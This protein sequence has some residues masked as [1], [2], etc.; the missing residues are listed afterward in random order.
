M[1]LI[2]DF[3]AKALPK[4]PDLPEL[5]PGYTVKIHLTVQEGKK[6]RV[7]TFEGLIIKM[8]GK[9]RE[10]ASIT[11]RRIASG[12]GVERIF[13]LISPAIQKIEVLKKA[14]VRRANLSYIRKLSGKSARLKE[15]YV[16]ELGIAIAAPEPTPEATPTPET[17]A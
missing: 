6:E 10:H 9:Q 4:L 15:S 1:S 8:H 13:P 7:Q 14:R 16:K 11:V 5:R 17:K 12:V 2:S 3:Q